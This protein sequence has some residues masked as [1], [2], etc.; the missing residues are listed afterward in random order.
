[1]TEKAGLGNYTKGTLKP[2]AIVCI[3]N[4]KNQNNREKHV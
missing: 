4:T 2:R 1:M 3:Y